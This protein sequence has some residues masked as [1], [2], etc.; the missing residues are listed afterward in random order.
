MAYN[1]AVADEIENDFVLAETKTLE[2]ITVF[3]PNENA[4]SKAFV[5]ANASK[6]K[7]SKEDKKRSDKEIKTCKR[8]INI[9]LLDKFKQ[10]YSGYEYTFHDEIGRTT[11]KSRDIKYFAV[12]CIEFTETVV[13]DTYMM[14]KLCEK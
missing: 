5:D 4:R 6:A 12:F 13:R 8:M 10:L 7:M 1:Q 3:Y 2:V 11:N 14:D 9:E